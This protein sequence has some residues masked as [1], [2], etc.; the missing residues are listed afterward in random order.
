MIKKLIEQEIKKQNKCNELMIISTSNSVYQAWKMLVILFC[1]ISSFFYAYF[2]TFFTQM[3]P[4]ELALFTEA[5]FYFQVF[6]ITD[7]ILNFF[8]EHHYPSS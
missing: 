6:F 3:K 2:A 5:D 4:D 7:M 1:F 8:V